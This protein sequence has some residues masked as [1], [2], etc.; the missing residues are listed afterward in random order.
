MESEAQKQV[1]LDPFENY[2]EEIKEEDNETGTQPSN[3]TALAARA[4]FLL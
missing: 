4:K 1:Q 3:D 2:L